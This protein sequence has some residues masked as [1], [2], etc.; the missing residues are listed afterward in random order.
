MSPKGRSLPGGRL[1]ATSAVK[2]LKH[3]NL[4]KKQNSPL[5]AHIMHIAHFLNLYGADMRRISCRWVTY[6]QPLNN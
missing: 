1:L 6:N 5:L 4:T 2:G 3:K